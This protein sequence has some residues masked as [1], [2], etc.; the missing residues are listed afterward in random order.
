MQQPYQLGRYT[1][2][3]TL[4]VGGFATVYRAW[5]EALHREAA[6]KVLHPHLAADPELRQ[7]FVTEAR[8]LARLR[9]PNIITVFDVG[10]ADGRPFFTMELLEGST[11]AALSAGGR[12]WPLPEAVKL[13]RDLAGALDYVHG[14]G[15][16]HR[17]IKGANVMVEQGGRVVLMDLGIARALNAT[18]MTA[19]SVLIGT[20][21]AMAPE[22][23]RGMAIGPAADIY[24]LG[25]LAFRLLSGRPPFTGDVAALVHAHAYEP[26][27]PLETYRPD[28]PPGMA[29]AVNAAM[30]KDPAQRPASAGAFVDL[31]D[32]P[33][34]PA[35]KA[36]PR[37]T[38]GRK[39]DAPSPED[40]K[41]AV[42]TVA[43]SL[44]A[45]PPPPASTL[46][47]PTRDHVSP[48][49]RPPTGT[50]A[51]P[52]PTMNLPAPPVASRP[53][54]SAGAG[55]WVA[56][57]CV[58]V[59]IGAALAVLYL[60]RS[61]GEET[62]TS[63]G[64]YVTG[65]V[66]ST[67][68]GNGISG[69]ADGPTNGAS[70]DRLTGVTVDGT[71]I[72]LAD[73]RNHRVRT[74][75]YGLR[76]GDGEVS[77]LAGGSSAGPTN[78][79]GTAA[80]FNLP[81]GVARDGAGATYVADQGNNVIRKI[82]RDGTVS[83][84]AGSGQPGFLDGPAAQAQFN[85]PAAVAVDSAGNVYVADTMNNRVRKITPQGAVSTLAGGSCA[86]VLGSPD[87]CIQELDRPGG[88]AVDAAGTVYVADTFNH[89]I[90]RVT[91]PS[92]L[93]TLAGTVEPGYV[94]GAATVARFREP[95]GLAVDAAEVVYVADS[96]NVRVRQ[97][98]ADGIVMTLAGTGRSRTEDGPGAI[99]SFSE[100][101]AVA[102]APDGAVVVAEPFWIRRI[103]HAAK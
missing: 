39:P 78:G 23:A 43:G 35:R 33:R 44:P 25:V 80:R 72:V 40:A 57:A 82:A 96:G 47:A 59:L 34:R 51:A 18:Q 2:R 76:F 75:P 19:A 87:R 95:R 6:L 88:I 65:A 50:R 48:P 62:P 102:V 27:P 46:A 41:G 10:E 97:V 9:H 15:F 29:A 17:D 5:D 69:F 31:L 91:G 81:F 103:T 26:P 14:Q 37:R 38:T 11:V 1:I 21:E 83:T 94:D 20:P 60:L 79:R 90:R 84:V 54:R 85:A 30:A 61:Q 93:V 73:S 99:A 8:T 12:A 101:T 45:Q 68:A 16:V 100:V 56:L 64:R 52:L 63:A 98:S 22:Q 86:P 4:G 53:V 36:A 58:V 66:V 89:R 24:A 67:I 71:G 42:P 55:R 28:L 92:N 77:T 49:P 13:L 74:L 7:R 32:P 70:F 3:T